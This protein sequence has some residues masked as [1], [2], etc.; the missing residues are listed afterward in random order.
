MRAAVITAGV[1]WLHAWG[2]AGV[3]MP[4]A[5]ALHRWLGTA[6]AAWALLTA[7]LSTRDERRGLRSGQF[8]AALLISA[9]LVG[10]TG[11]FGGILVHGADF[12]TAL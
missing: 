11:H 2:G 3:G 6:T 1:G 8:R 4:M 12:F 9:L 5:L 7:I 10:A